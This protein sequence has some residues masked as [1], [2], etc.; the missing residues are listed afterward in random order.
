MALTASQVEVM[1]EWCATCPELATARAAA[2]RTFFGEDDPRSVRYWPGAQDLPA[3]DH[4]F[5]GWFMFTQRLPDGRLPAELA[6]ERQPRAEQDQVLRAIRGHR[7]VLATVGTVL[8]GSVFLD[9]EDE[10]FDVRQR[11]W[12]RLFHRDLLVA[13][14]LLP[15]RQGVWLAGPGWIELPLAIGPTMR[16]HLKQFQL[17]PVEVER[18]L[19]GRGD[20]EPSGVSIAPSVLTLNDAVERMDEAAREL[21]LPGLVL[22]IAEWTALVREYLD[23]IAVSKFFAEVLRRAGELDNVEQAQRLSTLA[24]QIWNAT[25]QPDR[26]GVNAHELARLGRVRPDR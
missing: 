12:A 15:V 4:R 18:L 1:A 6:V 13:A 2:R 22:S 5:L 11:S 24:M 19:Q 20:P 7:Y 10:S 3:R 21:G 16:A 14:H 9:L 25:P 17:D 8:S 23:D 26:G